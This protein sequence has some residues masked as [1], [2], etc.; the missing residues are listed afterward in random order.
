MKQG[1]F[2]SW[3]MVRCKIRASTEAMHNELTVVCVGPMQCS[4][5]CT[6]RAMVVGIHDELHGCTYARPVTHGENVFLHLEGGAFPGILS[7]VHGGTPG[8]SGALRS[9]IHIIHLSNLTRLMEHSQW[10]YRGAP[11]GFE[12]ILLSAYPSLVFTAS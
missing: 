7:R 4:I 1:R 2:S 3:T 12:G 8:T 6:K 5:V 11:M 10:P 9:G